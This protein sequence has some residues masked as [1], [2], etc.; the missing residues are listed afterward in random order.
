VIKKLNKSG[1]FYKAG[2]I[3]KEEENDYDDNSESRNYGGDPRKEWVYHPDMDNLK[4]P[5]KKNVQED[6]EDVF[7][8]SEEKRPYYCTPEYWDSFKGDKDDPIEVPE[9]SDEK[10]VTSLATDEIASRGS[11]DS[12]GEDEV[13]EEVVGK[14]KRKVSNL[15]KSPYVVTKPTKRAKRSAKASEFYKFLACSNC[16]CIELTTYH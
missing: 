16:F 14:R 12:I 13:P 7:N 10:S 9:V 5:A 2:D 3:E 15:V 6:D 11:V 4:T 1:V 8:D